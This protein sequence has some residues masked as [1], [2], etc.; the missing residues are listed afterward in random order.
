[1]R[2][3]E[4]P[5]PDR[6]SL[7][8]QSPGMTKTPWPWPGACSASARVTFPALTMSTKISRDSLGHLS[9]LR[10]LEH[11]KTFPRNICRHSAPQ[12]AQIM[13][14]AR[15]GRRNSVTGGGT[16]RRRASRCGDHT[17][18]TDPNLLSFA[19]PF[20]SFSSKVSSRVQP[21]R[22]PRSTR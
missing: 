7:K 14:A 12:A 19:L 17:D 10:Y 15:Y 6:S 3:V 1:M 16:S 5:R 8:M 2:S 13:R 18:F 20:L 11:A 22:G 21:K 4:I 9:I